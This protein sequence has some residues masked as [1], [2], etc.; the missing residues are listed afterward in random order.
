MKSE[1]YNDII[2]IQ[3]PP[4][5]AEQSYSVADF[6][7]IVDWGLRANGIED[8]HEKS[9]G[10]GV[11]VFVLDTGMDKNHSDLQCNILGGKNFTDTGNYADWQDKHGHG[12]HVAGIIGAC[13]NEWGVI[14]VVPESKIFACKVLGDN[15]SGSSNWITNAINFA[16]EFQT[17]KRKIINLSLGSN[18]PTESQ[19]KAIGK[20]NKLNI[21]VVCAAGNSGDV[22]GQLIYPA[23]FP[24]SIAVGAYGK[25][26]EVS[27]FSQR[28]EGLD[29][30]APGESI[31]STIINE[32]YGIKSGTSMAAPF[33]SGVIALMLS[34]E[35]NL[36]IEEIR[37]LLVS[38]AIDA[39]ETGVDNEYGWGLI[40]PKVL[41]EMKTPIEPRPIV[42]P[43]PEQ[44][45]PKYTVLDV[46]RMIYKSKRAIQKKRKSEVVEICKVLNIDYKG[47]NSRTLDNEVWAIINK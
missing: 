24:E 43:K 41:L 8:L 12:T 19:R 3:L 30:C 4:F 31:I 9:K 14:G 44:P 32:Q 6:Q 26:F 25:D 47:K 36:I 13:A 5:E 20:A 15:G 37:K 23:G 2:D 21:P 11:I 45:E 35:P 39:G 27:D 28:G 29:V 46:L 10:K 42:E 40:N 7:Q 22:T 18:K 34:I 38:T 1:M 33:V 16:C 17:D